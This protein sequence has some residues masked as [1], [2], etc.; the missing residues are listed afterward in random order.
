MDGAGQNLGQDL[1][2]G[3]AALGVL[4]GD[5]FA[6]GRRDQVEVDEADALLFGEADGGTCRLADGV[7]GHGLWA[8]R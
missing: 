4:G 3:A 6:L 2:G 5:V 1:L 8:G 7:V